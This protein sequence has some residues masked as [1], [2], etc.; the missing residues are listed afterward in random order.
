MGNF[1]LRTNP[2]TWNHKTNNR[3]VSPNDIGTSNGVMGKAM[4]CFMEDWGSILADFHSLSRQSV[5]QQIYIF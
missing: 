4:Q 5:A 1:R 2:D 3:I